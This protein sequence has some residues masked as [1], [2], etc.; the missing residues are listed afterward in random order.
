MKIYWSYKQVPELSNRSSAERD[1]AMK[2][3]NSLA[4]RHWEWWAS[5]SV[6]LLLTS[7][8]G[9]YGGAG[10]GG[11]VGA[12]IGGGLGGGLLVQSIIHIARKYHPGT[13]R[14]TE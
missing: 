2:R 12:G 10:I 11:V 13:L 9:Y 4:P 5:F 14:G 6:A 1:A 8:G 7:L 3:I